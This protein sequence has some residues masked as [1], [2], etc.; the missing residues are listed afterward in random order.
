MP[1]LVERVERV[2]RDVARPAAADVD[3]EGRFPHEAFAALREERLLAAALPREL[4]GL[5]CSAS[6]IAVIGALLGRAC[7]STAAIYVMQQVQLV[8]I[9]R[10]AAGAS[11]FE[12]YL[13][14]L[15]EHQWLVASAS[16]EVGVGG[17]VR[18]SIAAIESTGGRFRLSK[19]CS[20][21]SYGEEADAILITARRG[22]DAPSGDQ[23]MAL[24]TKSD[25]RLERISSWNALGMR[26]TCSPGF[27]VTAEAPMEQIIPDPFRAIAVQTFVPYSCI[28][29]SAGWLG[30]AEEAVSI[31]T[32]FTRGQARKRAGGQAFGGARLVQMVN[33]L[34]TMRASIRAAAAEYDMLDSSPDRERC[35]SA[36]SS[37]LR[38][39]GLKQ[40]SAQLVARICLSSLEVC[41][42]AGYLNDSQHSV[43]RLV[44][45]ALSASLMINNDRLTTTNANLLILSNEEPS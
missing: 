25:Y 30:M 40:I 4:G 45:D 39:N 27:Q 15:S 1:R 31:A 23:V 7:A 38:F 10:H 24:L 41:G 35:L 44:R 26:G 36:M 9:A 22:P 29:W 3:R 14:R 20:V 21:L 37:A 13:R 28:A 43:G 8:S 19:K 16:S 2:A 33:E 12:H 34:G 17:D 5:G 6:D 32:S 18:T 42:I 11:F